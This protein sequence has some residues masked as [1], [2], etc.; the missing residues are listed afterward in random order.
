AGEEDEVAVRR[1][2]WARI[3]LLRSEG[4]QRGAIRVDEDQSRGRAAGTYRLAGQHQRG[5]VRRP[6]QIRPGLPGWAA[7]QPLLVGAAD[8]NP[9]LRPGRLLRQKGKVALRGPGETRR[10]VRQAPRGGGGREIDDN[11][12]IHRLDGQQ[13]PT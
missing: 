4:R 3:L 11:R 12:V 7:R 10:T 6:V 2:L 8:G 1:P 5:S 9:Q 13:L